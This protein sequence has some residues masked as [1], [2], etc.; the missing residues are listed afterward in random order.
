M[1]PPLAK[2]VGNLVKG[3]DIE[4]RVNPLRGFDYVTLRL[5]DEYYFKEVVVLSKSDYIQLQYYRSS[6][7]LDFVFYRADLQVD[8]L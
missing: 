4:R 5:A 2:V 3:D 7:H 8:T 1:M 6:F